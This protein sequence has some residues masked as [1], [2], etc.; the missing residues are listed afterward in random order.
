MSC[1]IQHFSSSGSFIVVYWYQV[2]HS[3]LNVS[4][5]ILL[6]GKPLT[7]LC[8]CQC[9]TEKGRGQCSCPHSPESLPETVI[10]MVALPSILYNNMHILCV[11][12]CVCLCLCLSHLRSPEWEVVSPHCLHHLE[13][14]CLVSCTNARFKRK[15][16]LKFFASYVLNPMHTPLHFRLLWAGL[17]LPTTTKPLEHS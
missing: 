7:P 5:S 2:S 10:Q 11:C 1:I 12:L 13:E 14:L 8:T 9:N 6:S 17:I 16:L 3:L 15:G 4:Q